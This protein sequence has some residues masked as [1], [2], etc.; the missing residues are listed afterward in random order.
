[1]LASR[2]KITLATAALLALLGCVRNPEFRTSVAN[3]AYGTLGDLHTLLARAELGTLRS[4]SS[5]AGQ[6]DTYAEVIGGF[7]MS[8]LLAAAPTGGTLPDDLDR[9]A[10]R[11]AAEVRQMAA[12]HRSAG[13]APDAPILRTVRASCDAAAAA[14]AAG[15]ASSW[16]L[17][18]VAGDL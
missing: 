6:A 14:V 17:T 15:E 1:M 3:H 10:A 13:L 11:C 16:V 18:T 8:R 7:E 4:R 12:E 9:S 2:L 5:F